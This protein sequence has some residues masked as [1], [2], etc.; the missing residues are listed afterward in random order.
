MKIVNVMISRVMGG[1]EQAFLDYNQALRLLDYEVLSIVDK[2]NV[3]SDKLNTP[4]FAIN[5]NKY[6][7][8]LIWHLYSRLKKFAPDVII[9]QSKKAIPLF[10]I[11]ANLLKAKLVGVAHNPKP[12]RLEKCDAI[13]SITQNQKD[14]LVAKGIKDVPITVVPNM[15]DIPQNEPLYHHFHHPAVIGTFGR[16]DPMK[17]FCD[18]IAALG[19]LKQRG[20]P[21]KAIIGGGNN[22]SYDDEER[23]ILQTA[24][25]CDLKEELEFCGW[26]TDKQCFFEQIDVFVMPSLH[27]PFGIVSLE[28]ALAKKAMICS[29]A[30]GPKE[31]WANAGAAKLFAKGNHEMLAD[32]IA[33]IILNPQQAQTMA[34]NEYKYVKE[35]Y[36][37]P[38]VA[39]ILQNALKKVIEG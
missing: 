25:D 28:A 4:I 38:V 34:E 32:T 23:R 2:K 10:R 20:I 17:G 1:I 29:D 36:S 18:F 13:F 33:D 5:F 16:F 31:V 19:I 39:N 9:V 11:V 27:E 3:I 35:H 21:F 22:G 26:V 30:E 7:P 24:A 6:N 14:V 37:V 8:L 15:I 12:K